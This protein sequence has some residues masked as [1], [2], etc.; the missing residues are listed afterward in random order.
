MGASDAPLEI[1]ALGGAAL[2]FPG[3]GKR[4]GRSGSWEAIVPPGTY[5]I[6][7]TLAD[8]TRLQGET[9]V[10]VELEPGPMQSMEPIVLQPEEP[11]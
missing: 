10:E 2:P 9:T 7:A 5:R 11:R 8:G 6:T 4:T 1:E 3:T